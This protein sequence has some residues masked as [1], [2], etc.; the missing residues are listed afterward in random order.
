M[1]RRPRILLAATAASLILVAGVVLLLQN[2]IGWLYVDNSN[3]APSQIKLV[4][5]DGILY[6]PIHGRL[7]IF[8]MDPASI[9]VKPGQPIGKVARARGV[10]YLDKDSK[11]T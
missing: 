2:L 3:P 4:S 11:G 6:T 1:K 9:S 5:L 7:A 10:D 8:Q